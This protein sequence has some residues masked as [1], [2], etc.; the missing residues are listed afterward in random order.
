MLNEQEA[1][2]LIDKLLSYSKSDELNVTLTGSRSGN[3]RYA[4]NAVSTNGETENLSFSVTAVFGKRSGSAA[5][6]EF[7]DATLER[8]VRR[9]EE[10]A[11]LAPENPEYMP[12]LEAQSYGKSN[13]FSEATAEIDPVFRVDAVLASIQECTK[14]K[15]ISAG[16]LQDNA[17]FLAIG[18]SKGLFGY[19]RATSGEFTVTARTADERGSGFGAQY[20]TDASTL[21]TKAATQTAIAKA[22]ASKETKELKPEPMTVILEPQAVYDLLQ[23]M[24]SAMD[25]RTADEGRNFFGK[26][27]VGNRIGDQLF[28]EK[29]TIYSDP[30]ST[31][32]PSS[33]F[34]PDGRP[35][36]KVTW[37]DKGVL[38]NLSYSRYWAKQ[39]TVE[40]VPPPSG[41]IVEGSDQSLDDLIK[42]S[43]KA[44]LVTRFWYIRMVD[45]QTLVHT[46]LTRDGT[47][48]IEDG[49]IK[50]AIKNFRFNESP[51]TMLANLEAVGKPVRIA[52]SMIPPMKIKAFNFSSLSDA[53]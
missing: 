35:Q 24:L 51:A 45:P 4:R 9:A 40:A 16:Y 18:N 21:N 49:K 33:P 19:N 10:V 50:N 5:G 47:F 27:G 32:N 37:V 11:R 31:E 22:V 43:D 15:I 2:A 36:Q 44:V 12:A 8:T 52:N 7:D 28:N 3:I 46:G 17:G 23:L 14:Q 1:K 38:K 53:V 48:Y 42:S 29:L 26:R 41:V 25:A 20:F 13:T 39:K 30:F 34:A 6:N